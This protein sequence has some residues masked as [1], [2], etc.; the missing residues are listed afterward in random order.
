V[1]LK[2][3]VFPSYLNQNTGPRKPKLQWVRHQNS[4]QRIRNVRN[5]AR[6]VLNSKDPKTVALLARV[7]ESVKDEP[8]PE[9]GFLHL[10]T[11]GASASFGTGEPWTVCMEYLMDKFDGMKEDHAERVRQ[12]EAA[13]A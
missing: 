10:V 8:E 1:R 11:A 13:N 12:Q 2:G 9:F 7:R 3:I 5:A 6:P 4:K